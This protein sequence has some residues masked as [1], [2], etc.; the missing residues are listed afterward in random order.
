MFGLI[1]MMP[2][3]IS[4]GIEAVLTE[5]MEMM[6]SVLKMLGLTYFSNAWVGAKVG[7]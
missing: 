5:E 7:N 2:L 6:T 1:V 3:A 4:I